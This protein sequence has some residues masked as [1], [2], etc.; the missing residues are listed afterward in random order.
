[1]DTDMKQNLRRFPTLLL[2]LALLLGC[3]GVFAVACTE[4][5][6]EKEELPPISFI[7][8]GA[9]EYS[10]VRREN[11]PKGT[12]IDAC[13]SLRKALIA[14]TGADIRLYDDYVARGES[15]PTDTLEILVGDTT[16]QESID[17]LATL[18]KNE[19]VIK[20]VGNR[21][22]ILG[23]NDDAT[24]EAVRVFIRD[25]LGYDAAA[26]SYSASDL[27]LAPDYLQGGVYVPSPTQIEQGGQADP[28]TPRAETTQ[29][30]IR[31]SN[32]TYNYSERKY[33]CN[34]TGQDN[35]YLHENRGNVLD[36]CRFADGT[37]YI[38]YKFDI[39]DKYEPRVT[40]TIGND[41]RI[42]ISP[43]DETW[44]LVYDW[45]EENE[46]CHDRSNQAA[47]TINPY[48]FEVYDTC[49]IRLSDASTGDGWGACFTDFTFA[50]YTEMNL[51]SLNIFNLSD[52]MYEILFDLDYT[53]ESPSSVNAY[54]IAGDGGL[55]YNPISREKAD[56][57]SKYDN[58][59][60]HTGS[61]KTTVSGVEYTVTYR[62][63]KNVTAYDAVP[64]WYEITSSKI[65]SAP[66]Y[67]E[68]TAF[69]DPSRVDSEEYYALTLP[70]KVDVTWEYLGYV[71]GSDKLTNRPL[72]RANTDKSKVG[73]Q[74]PQYHAS[75]LIYS[76]DVQSHD[77]LWWKFRYTNTGNTILDGDGNGTFCV[78]AKLY[79]KN[80]GSW[81]ERAGMENIY[82]RILEELYPGESG[83]M[84]FIFDNCYDL[85]AGE[86]KIVISSLV[87]NETTN[88]EN[89]GK[90]IWGG[91]VYSQS[92]FAFTISAKGSDTEPEAVKKTVTKQTA[93]RN[94]WMHRYEEFMSSYDTLLRGVTSNKVTDTMYVQVAPWTE[95]ITLRLIIGNAD[96]LQAV[97]LPVTVDTDSLKINFNPD[98]NNYVVLEDGTRFPAITAQ[99]MADMRGNVQ[100]GPDAA[101]NV[102]DNLMDMQDIG[103]NLINT[104]AAFEFDGSLG[105]GRANNIDACWFSLDAA[106]LLGLKTEGWICYPYESA[107]SL[108]QAN[109]LFGMSLSGTG[110]GSPDLAL[111]N[112]LNTLWQYLRWGDNFWIGGDDVVVLDVEDTRGW[113]RVDFNARF[114]MDESSKNNFR[115]F[116][117]DLYGDIESLNADWETEFTSF[118]QIDPEDGTTDDHGWRSYKSKDIVFAEWSRPM[119]VLDM[120]RTL[121]RIED[122]EMMLSEI[123]K[124]VPTA[125][126]NLRTEGANWLASVDPATDNSHFRHVYYSQRR[127]AIIPELMSEGG[128]LYAASDYTTLPYT[129]SE[130]AELTASSVEN[131]IIPMLLPQ[132]N[133]MRDIA[134]N[135]T[136]GNDFTYEYNLK[137]A[138]KGAYINTVCSV[139]EWFV[140]T[141][142]N[143]GV[144]GI[145][146]QDYLCDGYATETQRKEIAFFTE[147][148]T[149]ALNTAEGKAWAKNFDQNAGVL[150][151]SDAAWSYDAEMVQDLIDRVAAER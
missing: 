73:A 118:D 124:E 7:E 106:R 51:E 25:V 12:L 92:E 113:M 138:T 35:E 52:E 70:D 42:E 16:R 80:N 72:V 89:Y 145:L 135:T 1:M 129:P 151:G 8:N 114:T 74:Y 144:P 22:V 133:R 93:S 137:G 78:E 54:K 104:T 141:Y 49:Y 34:S 3:F 43:D 15:V 146:W 13:V 59:S 110:Y 27:K 99:S 30:L 81:V 107:G 90:N 83:E 123:H 147:K 32:G 143:G 140:A 46:N 19:Y 85:P 68:A 98:N 148:L 11:D 44:Q 125:L 64:I 77:L 71:G 149:E 139:Y 94:Q 26:D 131:G 5:E 76:G 102:L 95:Q 134:I 65:N 23:Q 96:T 75:E 119:E 40:Y 18:G 150:A 14:A 53:T 101:Y 111:A 20:V 62:V 87:R 105:T 2:C 29:P 60:C 63:P 66:V 117:I 9:T 79:I 56:Q 57:L 91:E 84:Y 132:F 21:L 24:A 122:Y 142:E 127:C 6:P 4:K 36:Y 116:L 47:Y 82:T 130:V 17:T 115:L 28:N 45:T 58:A 136:Y 109:T 55:I 88:P 112:A 126:I 128:V 10:I 121:E 50:Y 69:E 39:H 103:I 67:I 31:K 41:Y 108:T 120:F 33:D 61:F 97:A 37:G 38:I 86:Y 100:L 48:D